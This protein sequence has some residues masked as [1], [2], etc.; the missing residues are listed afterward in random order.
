MET[1]RI[2]WLGRQVRRYYAG[3]LAPFLA[4]RGLSTGEIDV[5]LFL[6][7]NPGFDTAR[8]VAELRG[9]G[10]SQISQAVELLVK[11]GFLCREMDETDRRIV[12]L[13]VTEAGKPVAKAAR[14]I[15]MEC[16]RKLMEGLSDAERALM[17]TMMEK[18][19]AN[20]SALVEKER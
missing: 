18:L 4:Q 5:L 12:H 3:Q 19:A 9:L 20:A 15:Q 1:W 11:R 13:T 6:Y 2:L 17:E 8:D 10:K 7:N 14:E 16:G